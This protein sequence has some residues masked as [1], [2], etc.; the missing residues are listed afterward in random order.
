MQQQC[1]KGYEYFVGVVADGDPKITITKKPP[2]G[3][4][5][6]SLPDG[7]VRFNDGRGG[8]ISKNCGEG[9]P[10]L[11]ALPTSPIFPAGYVAPNTVGNFY[12]DTGITA[13]SGSG[14]LLPGGALQNASLQYLN[15]TEGVQLSSDF[16]P[17][18]EQPSIGDIDKQIQN[19]AQQNIEADPALRDNA[20]QMRLCQQQGTCE[21]GT[22]ESENPLSTEQQLR[23]QAQQ[24]VQKDYFSAIKGAYG[25]SYAVD[26]IGDASVARVS[27]GDWGA[28]YYDNDTGQ[29][30][31]GRAAF[32][33]A[34]TIITSNGTG[35]STAGSVSEWGGAMQDSIDSPTKFNA[36]ESEYMDHGATPNSYMLTKEGTEVITHGACP[37]CDKIVPLEGFGA[38]RAQGD[39]VYGV[40]SIKAQVADITG[41]KVQFDSPSSWPQQTVDGLSHAPA[42]GLTQLPSSIR[43]DGISNVADQL[44]KYSPEYWQN[45][46]P[47]T[48]YTYG[49][50]TIGP[51]INAGGYHDSRGFIWVNGSGLDA[52]SPIYNPQGFDVAINHEL[53][54]LNSTQL[55]GSNLRYGYSVY[56]PQYGYAYAG[57]SGNAAIAD[58][59]LGVSTRPEGFIRDYG[60][61]GGIDEDQAT[62]VDSMFRNYGAVEQAA[63]TDG[64]LATKVALA[65]QGFSNMSN[66]VMNDAYW[67]NLKPIDPAFTLQPS[68]PTQFGHWMNIY[69]L[70]LQNQVQ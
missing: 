30:F 3:A 9:K 37:T 70:S 47:V 8:Y 14:S 19:A 46:N 36:L 41:G 35:Y 44:S 33:S 11:S 12:P 21:M 66:G 39:A 54:H 62:V 29:P 15:P 38:V 58:G 61:R 51:P 53:A 18:Y 20:F 65:K 24:A 48:I 50:A 69:F 59:K 6:K 55:F 60:Y 2:A 16:T 42:A 5:P 32:D 4:D 40:D 17:T 67:Q 23:G 49:S 57:E 52:G 7:I 10:V 28:R 34:P 27:Q 56:G 26:P 13:D 31:L 68:V 43:A 63:Q 64:T 1:L 25:P 45:S 22:L